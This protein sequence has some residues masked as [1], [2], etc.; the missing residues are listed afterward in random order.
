MSI[1]SLKIKNFKSIVQVDIKKIPNFSVF[2]GSNGSGKSNI[3]EALEFIRD[4]VRNG[5]KEAIKHHNG[6]ENIHSHKLR[7]ANAKKFYTKMEIV[8]GE[9]S[10][11]YE[12]E[13][14]ELDKAPS[15][16]ETVIK[17]SVEIAKKS[18]QNNIFI[19]GNKQEIDYSKNETILKLISKD[20]QALLEYL[21]SIERYQIDPVKAKE[22]DDF[23]ASDVLYK[24][25][26]NIST[27][28][29][30]LEKDTTIAEEI[31]ETM[32]MIVPGLEKVTIETEKLNNKSVLVFKEDSVKKR[33][34]AGLISDGTIY[35]LA[36]LTIIYSNKQGMVLIEEPERGLNP[37]AI[38]EI[39]EFFRDK[40]EN[41][42]IFINTHSE[43]IV[44]ATKPDELFLVDKKDGKTEIKNVKQTYPKYDYSS[45]DVDRMWMSN[46]FDGGL[47]W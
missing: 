3:F 46:M 13:I 2:A 5:A 39:V 20:A 18:I 19:N 9:D 14:K 41:F 22:A 27:V 43:S 30:K 11:S 8:L 10:Y 26:S 38:A 12:L 36:M 16:Y 40:S 29:G 33:F 15:I 17:N 44:R 6:Y 35:A 25:A 7:D 21:I 24:D 23:Y 4:V 31:I 47:P 32:Q 37:K 1:K 42:N 28:L 34:P 45:M